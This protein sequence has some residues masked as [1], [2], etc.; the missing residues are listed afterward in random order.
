[1]AG[2]SAG[3]WLTALGAAL[4]VGA[5]FWLGGPRYFNLE[6]LKTSR[7]GLQGLYAAHPA[8]MLT[9]YFALYVAAAALNLP[10]SAVLT[11]A[12]SAV[13]GF[14][15]GLASVSFASS[16]GATMACALSR[17]LLRD[18]VRGRFGAVLDKV[19]RGLASEG[20]WYLASLRLVPVIPF[21]LI[22]LVMGLT[23]MP[24]GRF[25]V[26]SQLGMLPGTIVFVNAGTELGRVDKIGDI[27]SPGVLG[28][29]A[30]LAVFPVAAKWAL[31]RFRRAKDDFR[32]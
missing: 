31:S 21:F 8:A 13:F 9:G 23:R 15:A 24:L 5:F 32:A 14:W 17:Y 10:G 3:K 6:T 25:Y 27:L 12:G 11:L 26:V 18:W 30:L 2:K 20:A 4:A 1:M 16:L 28:S 7:D 29:L 19:D 22:N